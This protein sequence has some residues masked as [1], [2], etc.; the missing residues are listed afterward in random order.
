M[1]SD[2]WLVCFPFV[3]EKKYVD[4]AVTFLLSG[5]TVREIG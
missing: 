5:R 3:T 2:G 4:S 1:S